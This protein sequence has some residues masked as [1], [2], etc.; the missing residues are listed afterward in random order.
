ML[1]EDSAMQPISLEESQFLVLGLHFEAHLDLELFQ[2]EQFVCEYQACLMQVLS[3]GLPYREI[4]TASYLYELHR[5]CFEPVFTWAGT[6][7]TRPPGFVGIAPEHI[8]TAVSELMETLV[9]QLK[10]VRTIPTAQVA[11]RAHHELVRIHAF[12]DGNGRVSRMFADLLLASLT[13]PALVFNWRDTPEYIP[14]LRAAD[15]TLDYAALVDH[16]G[17]TTIF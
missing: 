12:V 10:H 8:R 1:L 4:L 6:V 2:A 9:Y 7:R 11:M 5:S 13:N 17:T 16:V 3:G 14:L 15:S